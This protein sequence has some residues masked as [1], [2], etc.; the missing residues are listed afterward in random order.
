MEKHAVMIKISHVSL[1]PLARSSLVRLSSS[2]PIGVF[3]KGDYHLMAARFGIDAARLAMCK[4]DV[5]GVETLLAAARCFAGFPASVQDVSRSTLWGTVARGQCRLELFGDAARVG[6]RE[7]LSG[8]TADV[9]GANLSAPSR[10]LLYDQLTELPPTLRAQAQ[11]VS[12][13]PESEMSAFE[14]LDDT[15]GLLSNAEIH[16]ALAVRT[17]QLAVSATEVQRALAA[18]RSACDC[19]SALARAELLAGACPIQVVK[20]EQRVRLL[21]R[22]MPRAG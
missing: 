15:V 2:P 17:I 16:T 4:G 20:P 3:T 18:A 10:V 5:S 12:G 1:L 13:P 14:E 9:F 19:L 22:R 8:A 21:I 6:H 7:V 11:N